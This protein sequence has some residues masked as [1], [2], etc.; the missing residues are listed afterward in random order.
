MIDEEDCLEDDEDC[1]PVAEE[2]DEE[3]EGYEECIA[4][5]SEIIDDEEEEV[6]ELEILNTGELMTTFVIQ[7][8]RISEDYTDTKKR[9]IDLIES[10]EFFEIFNDSIK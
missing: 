1:L 7:A 2:C 10:P 3:D 9:L 6:I 8:D 4:A 5:Q